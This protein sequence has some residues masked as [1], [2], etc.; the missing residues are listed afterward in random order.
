MADLALVKWLVTNYH[1]LRTCEEQEFREFCREL[2]PEYVAPGVELIK[3]RIDRLNHACK[4]KVRHFFVDSPIHSPA[5]TG[6]PE[7]ALRVSRLFFRR[8]DKQGW[9]VV[10]LCPSAPDLRRFQRRHFL[11]RRERAGRSVLVGYF[12][13]RVSAGSHTGEALRSLFRETFAAFEITKKVLRGVV[14]GGSNYVAAL[15][16]ADEWV[17]DECLAHVLQNCVKDCVGVLLLL[18]CTGI[19]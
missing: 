12:V 3:D 2:N 4:I 9:S 17:H 14:D 16:H 10:Y 18:S 11:P 19:Y 8:V 6:V 1:P 15:E 13:N 5:D 7:E